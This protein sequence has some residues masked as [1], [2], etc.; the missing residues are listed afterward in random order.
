MKNAPK[1]TR[2]PAGARPAIVMAPITCGMNVPRSPQAPASSEGSVRQRHARL[3]LPGS[4][5]GFAW[6]MAAARLSCVMKY[7]AMG[8]PRSA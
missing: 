1:P 5:R 7:H 4:R 8:L 6:L 3:A 2:M